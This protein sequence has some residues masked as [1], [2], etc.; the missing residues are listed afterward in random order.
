MR[1]ILWVVFIFGF[2]FCSCSNTPENSGNKEKL[3]AEND[4]LGHAT[5]LFQDAIPIPD[6]LGRFVAEDYPITNDM[7]RDASKKQDYIVWF[8]NDTLNQ[9]IGMELYT[10]YHRLSI[11]CFRNDAVPDDLLKRSYLF[12]NAS[13][14]VFSIAQKM[15]KVQDIVKKA[16]RINS[17]FF[18]TNKGFVLG[19]GKQKAIDCYGTPDKQSLVDGVEIWDWKF[20]GDIAYDDRVDLKRK[21]VAMDSFGQEITMYFKKGKLVGQII[22]NTAP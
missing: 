17:S 11:V 8:C 13:D 19:A 9:T 14:T 5:V 21:P 16:E 4:S 15:K 2:T 10:D 3:M 12:A 20:A 22:E 1:I 6:M 18:T 7:L